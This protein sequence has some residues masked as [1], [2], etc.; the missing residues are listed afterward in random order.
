VH[1]E[2]AVAH[3]S[4]CCP[5]FVARGFDCTEGPGCNSPALL[6]DQGRCI[7]GKSCEA[8]VADGTCDRARTVAEQGRGAVQGE[9]CR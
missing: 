4:D 2:E 8:L 9:V 7:E 1:C 3:L 6:E 5:G